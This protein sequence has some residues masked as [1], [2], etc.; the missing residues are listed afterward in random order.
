MHYACFPCFRLLAD[1]P[2]VAGEVCFGCHVQRETVIDGCVQWA[3]SYG[4]LLLMSHDPTWNDGCCPV[5]VNAW[6]RYLLA[7]VVVVVQPAC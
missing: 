2:L 3:V 7:I 4:L 5:V 6:C 1:L